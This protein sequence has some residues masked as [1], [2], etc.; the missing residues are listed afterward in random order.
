MTGIIPV[1]EEGFSFDYFLTENK[2]VIVTYNERFDY[3][4]IV[5]NS[6]ASEYMDRL[7]LLFWVGRKNMSRTT[8][9]WLSP[10]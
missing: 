2:I 4:K 9:S 7:Y 5:L 6:K 10:M 8:K 3:L 1:G